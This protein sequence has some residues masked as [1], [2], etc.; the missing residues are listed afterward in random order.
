MISSSPATNRLN[1]KSSKLTFE[2]AYSN[3]NFACGQNCFLTTSSDGRSKIPDFFLLFDCLHL[4][5]F[6][7]LLP[8][9]SSEQAGELL[10]DI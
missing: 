7:K 4:L 1:S 8:L 6:L 5:C 9:T 2:P 3:C 10:S